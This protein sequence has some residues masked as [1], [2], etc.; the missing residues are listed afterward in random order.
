ML[1]CDRCIGTRPQSKRR[2]TGTCDLCKA[3]LDCNDRP[4]L[5]ELL[6][7]VQPALDQLWRQGLLKNEAK[8]IPIHASL[9]TLDENDNP[10]L[11]LRSSREIDVPDF[12]EGVKVRLMVCEPYYH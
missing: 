1:Y 3:V 11:E 7:S 10:V 4:N 9:A 12:I 5:K 2:K 6:K 8:G